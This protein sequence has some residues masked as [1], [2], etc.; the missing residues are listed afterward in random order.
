MNYVSTR[1]EKTTPHSFSEVLLYGLAKD[2]GLFIPEIYPFISYETL[3]HYQTLPY[4]EL[5]FN[6]IEKYTNNSIPNKDLKTIINNTYTSDKFSDS[7]ITPIEKL[8]QNI[9]LQ[10]L[11]LGPSLAFKD[12]AMQFLG[13]IIE[14]ELEKQQK[15]LT[16][17]GASSGDTVS[18]AEE[19]MRSKKNINVVMLTPKHGMSDFQKAQAGTILDKNIFNV[20][21]D[22][23]F[24]I[25]QDLVKEVNKDIEFK[26]KYNI[27]AVNSI[28]WGRICAQIV[29]YVYGYLNTV[30]DVGEPLDVIVPSGNFGNILAGYIAKQMGLPLR[31]LII[32]TNENKVLDTLFK[33]GIYKQEQVTKT[34]S[35]SMDISKASNFERLL[36]D[37]LNKNPKA[38]QK[39][40]KQFEL[41]NEIDLSKTIKLLTE[42]ANFKSEST[43]HE[44]RIKTIKKVFKDTKRIIDPHTATAVHIA[45]KNQHSDIPM[46]CMETAKPTKFENSINEAINLIPKRDKKF[47]GIENKKQQ[48]FNIEANKDAIKDFI[49]EKIKL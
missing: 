43:N 45:I 13:N 6:I 16:I 30:K 2:G 49:K 5:A 32:A 18:A 40:M 3:K 39:L 19:A 24:D 29:Y 33:T 47:I 38:C 11:S 10:D 48:F 37:S 4:N 21:I 22:G 17:L 15:T 28:N 36:Y 14:Y 25:C 1:D 31:N 41:T 8:Y 44:D 27:G 34:N 46:L 35:P 7:K 23:T 9:Y 26:E 12:L 20:S 42:E